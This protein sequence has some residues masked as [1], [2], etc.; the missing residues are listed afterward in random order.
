MCICLWLVIPS[1]AATYIAASCS[2][3]DVQAC[4]N[5]TGACTGLTAG[6]TVRIPA[7]TCHWTTGVTWTVPAGITLL[8]AGTS[9]IGGGDQT[10]IIDDWT[11]NTPLLRL[12][13]PN[14]GVFRM[15]GITIQGGVGGI[16]DSGMFTIVGPGTVRLDH[17]HL[18]S[19]TYSPTRTNRVLTVGAGVYGV[20]DHSLLTLQSVSA[21]Y[22]TNGSNSG[23]TE[24]AA[25]TNFGANNYFVLE[26][27]QIVGTASPPSTRVYDC[28]T[29]GRVVVRFNSF[30]ASTM[31]EDHATGHSGD[32]RGCRSH[33]IYGNSG[34]LAGGQTEPNFNMIDIGGGTGVVWGNTAVES[35]KNVHHVNI[36]RK[37][38][39][40][41]QQAWTPTAWGYCGPAPRGTGTVDTAGT[42]VTHASGDLFN[43]AWPANTLIYIGAAGTTEF[44]IATVSS[45]TALTLTTSAGTQ[46][47]VTYRV[48]S[49]WDSNLGTLGE[50]CLDQPGRG[51]GDLLTGQFPNKVNQATGTIAYPNQALE[52]L[53]FWNNTASVAP[54][55]GGAYFSN[56]T[57]GRMVA[58]RDYYL[59]ASGIQISATSP[60]N[61]TVDTGWGTLANRPTTCTVGVAYFATDQGAW[62]VSTSNPEGVQQNGA[63]GVLYTCTSTNTWTLYYT[64]L[65]YP[66]P[67]T[68]LGGGIPTIATFTTAGTFTNGW[69]APLGVTIVTACAVGG[70]GAGAQRTTSGTPHGGGGGGGASACKDIAVTPGNAYTYTVGA[71][72]TSSGSPTNG[73]LSRFT[74]DG[75][76]KVEAAGGISAAANSNVGGAG[77]TTAASDGTTKFAGGAGFTTSASP[78]NAGGGGA[79]GGTSSTGTSATSATG[80]SAVT[81]GGPGGNGATAN[82]TAGSAPASGPGGGGGGGK[83]TSGGTT[84]LGGAGFAGQVML[85]YIAALAAP[86]NLVATP[87]IGSVG[88][89]W[90]TVTDATGYVVYRSVAVNTN[91]QPLAYNVPTNSYDDDSAVN[92]TLYYYKVTS[93]NSTAESVFS[94]EA[95]ATP[96]APEVSLSPTSLTF[97]DQAVDTTSAAQTVTL[98]NTGGF[99][100]HITSIAKSGTNPTNFNFTGCGG[101]SATTVAASANCVLN[102]TFTPSAA[103]SRTASL[104]ITSDAET[105]VDNVPLSGTGGDPPEVTASLL[106]GTRDKI[107]ILQGG[108]ATLTWATTDTDI[109]CTIDQGVGAVSPC[110]GGNTVVSPTVDT[111]YTLTAVGTTG[112][113]Q[114]SVTVH[115]SRGHGN[116][117]S[118]GVPK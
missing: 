81:G 18:N 19:Q 64:P 111:T 108:S 70:G 106:I 9:V 5:G 20:L 82:N 13:V 90:N 73:G 55:W 23:N 100:L 71:G 67:L 95:S 2:S 32:D 80:A 50:P 86:T 89:D 40:T 45:T 48:G 53:Y 102:V 110:S 38:F 29:G 34:V 3:A 112:S 69:T 68:T 33:E 92:G 75:G 59:E 4:F 77:G 88:L 41:Y 26:D 44:T 72:G 91:Y 74:G 101:G 11:T 22:I 62:N 47:G 99:T 103:G 25:A 56:A 52:P 7:G 28:L 16:K 93:L 114:A 63:D 60:F 24:W 6:D 84:R 115:V 37:N 42:A 36:T 46:T 39:A 96:D 10:V 85:T 27:N 66:H 65:Q 43:T 83:K 87:D 35:Y 97:A 94:N 116:G 31:G 79:S 17:M 15:S 8:G 61:G 14:S 54:G 78:S 30:V 109:S 1:G 105:S 118:H 57:G 104:D 21:V 58:N 76:S 117:H 12:T 51:Q 49:D 107:A 113:A 98:T